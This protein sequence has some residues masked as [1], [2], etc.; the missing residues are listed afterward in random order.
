MSIDYSN[1][2][3]PKNIKAKEETKNYLK[4]TKIRKKSKKLA[5]KEKNRFSIL[6]NDLEKCYFCTNKKDD[7]HEVFRGRNRQKSIEY[8]LV[9]PICSKCHR[10]MDI[11]LESEKIE[12]I[13]KKIFIEKYSEEKFL[14]EFK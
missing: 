1:F 10:K 3:F 14:N 2:A 5:K 12:K 11:K 6:T 9:I 8:G 4:K 13:A 7:L